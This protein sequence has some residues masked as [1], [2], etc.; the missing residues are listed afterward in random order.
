MKWTADFIHPKGW[1]FEIE[2]SELYDSSHAV[3][4]MGYY[5]YAYDEKD[6]DFFDCMQDSLHFAKEQAWEE[7]GVPM[8]SWQ[9]IG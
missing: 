9:Q 4:G 2:D 1:R 6:F 8:D 5:L 3:V 7:F